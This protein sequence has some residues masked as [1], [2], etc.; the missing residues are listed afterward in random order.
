MWGMG[1]G[2]EEQGDVFCKQILERDEQE[3]Y[4]F[5]FS[6]I[7]KEES[8]SKSQIVVYQPSQSNLP[9]LGNSSANFIYWKNQDIEIGPEGVNNLLFKGSYVV[10]GREGLV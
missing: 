3:G 8:V 4:I 7:I 2:T 6:R 5:R 9:S 10:I 1:I